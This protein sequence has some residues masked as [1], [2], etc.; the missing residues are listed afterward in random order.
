MERIKESLETINEVLHSDLKKEQEHLKYAQEEL[1]AVYSLLATLY[2][3]KLLARYVD[4]VSNSHMKLDC[5][6]TARW[7]TYS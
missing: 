7:Y 2:I 3:C 5:I 4:I 1:G 6:Y